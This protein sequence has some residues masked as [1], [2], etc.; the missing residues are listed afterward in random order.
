MKLNLKRIEVYA[1]LFASL[2]ALAVAVEISKAGGMLHIAELL[3]TI[4][5]SVR[6]FITDVA[7]AEVGAVLLAR[8]FE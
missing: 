8:L 6:D 1:A 7:G 5:V 3:H 2:G 4:A